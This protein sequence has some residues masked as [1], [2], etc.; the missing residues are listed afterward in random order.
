M[1]AL[2][3]PLCPRQ[4]FP[5]QH[6]THAKRR[7]EQE[8]EEEEKWR[9]GVEGRNSEVCEGSSDHIRRQHPQPDAR[10]VF[11]RGV[12]AVN[13]ILIWR[14]WENRL[15]F[16]PHKQQQS[17][18]WSQV[19]SLLLVYCC[20][21]NKRWTRGDFFGLLFSN[22]FSN[23]CTFFMHSTWHAIIQ[24]LKWYEYHLNYRQRGKNSDDTCVLIQR[25][26]ILNKS[27]FFFR[28]KYIKN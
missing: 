14:Q 26:N 15:T 20:A 24:F 18:D 25:V 5:Q 13:W 21:D 10:I 9:G 3:P 11:V 22:F 16:Y 19:R 28:K 27:L 4:H 12:Y 8:E 7:D 17:A 6:A 1:S 23:F 2:C